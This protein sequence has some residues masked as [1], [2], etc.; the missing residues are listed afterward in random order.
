MCQAEVAGAAGW[1]ARSSKR[2]TTGR[3]WRAV[4]VLNEIRNDYTHQLAPPR[5]K[6]RID[7]FLGL[8]QPNGPMNSDASVNFDL[9]LWSLFVAV[10]DLVERPTADVLRLVSRSA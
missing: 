6:T 10:A 9:A 1:R 3:Y 4:S 2:A 7:E 8:I 5:V